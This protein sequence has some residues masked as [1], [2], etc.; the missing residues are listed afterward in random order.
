M[1]EEVGN[2]AAM[3]GKASQEINTL[4]D[5]SIKTVEAFVSESK[6]KITRITETTQEK[7]KIG[8]I[9]ANEC[10]DSLDLI[11]TNIHEAIRLMDSISESS[12]EQL[13]GVDDITR[14]MKKLSEVIIVNTQAAD[15][16]ADNSNVL[17]EQAMGIKLVVDKLVKAAS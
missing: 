1:A 4:L 11:A 10:Q 16:S 3:S 15:N 17:K 14:A 12:K 6:L 9:T 5:N 7:I 8:S 13:K 2:L